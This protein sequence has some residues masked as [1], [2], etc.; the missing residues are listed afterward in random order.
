[1]QDIPYDVAT[2][3]LKKWVCT[4]KWPP[5]IAEIRESATSVVLPEIKDWSAAWSDVQDAMRRFGYYRA[6]EAV[7]SLDP[8]TRE[9][10]K[11]LG[12][13]KLCIS[14]NE[15]ADRANFRTIYETIAQRKKTETLIPAKIKGLIKEIRMLEDKKDES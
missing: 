13:S 5:S 6:N 7:E 11:R 12:F 9:T 3:S 2:I 4:N 15:T 14:E 10:V 1:M 8:V